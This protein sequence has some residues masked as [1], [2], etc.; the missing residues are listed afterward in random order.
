MVEQSSDSLQE[1][2]KNAFEKSPV[3]YA[4]GFVNGLGTADVYVV[5]QLNSQNVAVLNMSHSMAKTLAQSLID[6]VSRYE[7]L[8]GQRVPTLQELGRFGEKP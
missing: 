2:I 3:I 8:T 1:V 6:Q 7:E 4:N 5:L